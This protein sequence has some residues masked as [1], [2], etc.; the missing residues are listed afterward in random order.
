MSE[1]KGERGR[2]TEGKTEAGAVGRVR[3]MDAG[4]VECS[5][6]KV[7]KRVMR[8]RIKKEVALVSKP[9]PPPPHSLPFPPSRSLSGAVM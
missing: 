4:R 5:E 7:S 3:G 1:R 6:G 2:Q 9:P 8:V